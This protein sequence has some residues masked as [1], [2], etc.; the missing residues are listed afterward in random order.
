MKTYMIIRCYERHGVENTPLHSLSLAEAQEHC[1]D[2]E[3]DSS[4]CSELAGKTR[5]ELFGRWFD[6]FTEE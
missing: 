1:K 4:T 2:R 5:T 3:S 6:Y